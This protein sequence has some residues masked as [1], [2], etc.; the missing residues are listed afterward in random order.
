MLPYRPFF[1]RS[2]AFA[3]SLFLA[4]CAGLDHLPPQ[5]V[6]VSLISFNDFHGNLQPPTASVAVRDADSGEI[7]K[8]P[9]GGVAHLATLVNSLKAQ[10]SGNTLVVAAGDLVSAS[11]QVS[12]MFHDEPT[13]D[14]LNILGLEY[15]AVGNHEF[16][17]GKT[18]LLRL[19]NGGCFPKAAD[20]ARGIV[21]VDTCM[22]DGKFAGARFRYLAANVIDTATGKPLL[23]PYAVKTI[24]GV[25]IGLIGVTLQSA[26]AV[27]TPSGVV[28]LRFDD[29]AETV[30]RLVPELKQQGVASIVVL[31]HQGADSTAD[32]VND[33]SCPGFKGEAIE[34]VDKFD[35]AVDVVITAH[36]HDDYVCTR[37][38][39]K[40]VTQAGHYGRMATKIDLQI[41]PAQ[42]KVIGKD[43]NN[44][45]V[46][47][48]DSATD[49][50]GAKTPLP[51]GYAVLPKEPKLDALVERYVRLTAQQADVVVASI[52]APLS[53]K[54][55]AAGESVLGDVVADAYLAATSDA[56]YRPEPA[57]IAFVNPGG[58]RNGLS[59]GSLQVTYGQLY[60]IHPFSNN[61]VSMDLTGS[62][63]L[64]L[65]EQQWEKPQPPG[66]R[67]LSVSDG[68]TYTW[69]ASQPEG[70]PVGSGQRIVPGS[71]KLHGVPLDPHKIYRITTNSYLASGGDN[72]RIF[73]Q[74]RRVQDGGNDLDML[75]AYFRSRQPVAPPERKR[76]KRID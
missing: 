32:A 72:F 39:G 1:I 42:R 11:P 46:V 28:G 64:R 20:G 34:I 48:A 73:T 14:A 61:L 3:A 57:Q 68:F 23:P 8:V 59:D 9:A 12:G 5:G 62:Q 41:D 17:K 49:V 13:I 15:S 7:R 25:K 26:P 18:E 2:L 37:P 29:E 74:G 75:T 16:D 66:G 63:L 55:N 22:N 45:V 27:V 30:N 24:G 44:H 47:N 71:V 43:A 35:R 50:R 53:R 21:G 6:T 38:D 52:A 40:L 76:I 19:Q 33:K 60:R 54:K 56:S 4:S 69:D 36:T 65:L 58:L 70:A 51:A 10:N 31:M 67:I